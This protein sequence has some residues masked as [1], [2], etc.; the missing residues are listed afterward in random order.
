M[1][2]CILFIELFLLVVIILGLG[3]FISNFLPGP[4]SSSAPLCD[5]G[6]FSADAWLDQNANGTRDENDPPLAN[7]CIWEAF[8][9]EDYKNTSVCN[10]A[11][12]K[13]DQN[14]EWQSMFYAGCPSGDFFIYIF[15]LSPDGFKYTTPPVVRSNHASFGFAPVN[16]QTNIQIMPVATY[17]QKDFEREVADQN[18]AQ[19]EK[20]SLEGLA[21]IIVVIFLWSSWKIAGKI[22]A[23]K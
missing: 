4:V 11:M 3:A 5:L 16:M 14:G 2:L 6:E 12:N 1:A 20:W 15:A 8:R 7:V 22:V 9:P 19:I 10:S 18:L 23:L 21:V 17:L 13:T